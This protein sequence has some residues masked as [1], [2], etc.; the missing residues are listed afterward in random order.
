VTRTLVSADALWENGFG[1]VFP[2]LEGA[3]AFEDVGATLD[4][5]EELQPAVVIPGHGRVFVD[6][7]GALLRARS[8]LRAY[9]S[10]PR[11]H[12]AH[13]AK[14]LLK[15]KLLDLQT[16]GKPDFVS[17]AAATPYLRQVHS[18][19]FSDTDIQE[20]VSGLLS[21]LEQGGALRYEQGVLTNT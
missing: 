13:A 16:V 12:G 8:R 9:V 14:V 18:R 4:L 17:W 5:I 11:R 7:S 3:R 2:E 21:E 1:I 20:W 6:V 15:F 19:F 10:D